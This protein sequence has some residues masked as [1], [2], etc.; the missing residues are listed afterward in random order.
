MS[1]AAAGGVIIKLWARH[2]SHPN[3]VLIARTLVI[4][5]TLYTVSYRGLGAN[6]L[7]DLSAIGFTPFG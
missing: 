2:V 7:S 5:N 4:G 3:G 6:R 1:V